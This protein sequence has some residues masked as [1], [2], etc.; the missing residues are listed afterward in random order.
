MSKNYTLGPDV[1]A[2]EPVY[3]SKGNLIDDGYID[4]AIKDVHR[5]HADARP[6]C[7]DC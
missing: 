6:C 5:T 2:D 3:D 4:H 1:P 7:P